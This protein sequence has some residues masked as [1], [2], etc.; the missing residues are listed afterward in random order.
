MKKNVMNSLKLSPTE[1]KNI[2]KRLHDLVNSNTEVSILAY[3]S[4]NNNG[5]RCGCKGSCD[6]GCTSW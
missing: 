1:L 3:A 6:G 4:A 2:S 5:P